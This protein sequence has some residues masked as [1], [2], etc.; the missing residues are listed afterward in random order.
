MINYESY[1]KFV[2]H[3]ELDL[4]YHRVTQDVFG[5][6]DLD[7]TLETIF[8][9]HRKK[10]FPHY[11]IP[12]H[13][14]LQQFKSL[15]KFDEQTLF[16]DG[17][18]DQTMHGLSLAWTYFPHWVDVICGSSKLSPIE[19]WN[20]DDKLKEIIRKTWDW[21]LKHGNGSRYMVV[22]NQYLTLDHLQQNTSTIPM[23]TKELY[24]I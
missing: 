14:R 20:N 10:G 3:N 15:Q 19:Y 22:I 6:Q 13:K 23:V 8:Q 12:T 9:Y 1:S 11:D 18:I 17:K 5:N 16:K 21:Q 4:E 7:S 24:G 2:E